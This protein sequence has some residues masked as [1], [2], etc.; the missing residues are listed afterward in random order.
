MHRYLTVLV[1]LDGAAATVAAVTA[2]LVRFTDGPVGYLAFSVLLPF[3]W[4]AGRRA[5]RRAL[6]GPGDRARARGVPADLP[7]VRGLT[8]TIGFASYA[9][10][11]TSPAATS[12][13]ALPLATGWPASGTTGLPQ[14]DAPLRGSVG[15]FTT[16]WRSAARSRWPT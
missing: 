11:R 9:R 8:A 6:R 16:S 5:V 12:S 1:M 10:R 14:A 7:G 2:Y 3:A 13:S 4:V 15:A